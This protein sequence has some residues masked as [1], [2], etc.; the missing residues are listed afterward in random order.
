MWPVNGSRGRAQRRSQQRIHIRVRKRLCAVSAQVCGGSQGA[1][2]QRLSMC[3][4]WLSI[5]L[6]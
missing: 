4:C 6:K 3:R 1:R 2:V 5:F